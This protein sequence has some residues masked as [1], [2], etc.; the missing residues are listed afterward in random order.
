[1]MLVLFLASVF[2]I[3][4]FFEVAIRT[5]PRESGDAWCHVTCVSSCAG[6]RRKWAV[7]ITSVKPAGDGP[8]D[9]SERMPASPALSP[10]ALPS[11]PRAA[12]ELETS[13]GCR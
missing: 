9:S 3:H 12:A 5:V 10:S 1:M 8:A 7:V 4:W 2:N 13:P 6:D 11:P